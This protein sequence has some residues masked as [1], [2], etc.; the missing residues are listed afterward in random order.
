MTPD[1]FAYTLELTNVAAESARKLIDATL[2]EFNTSQADPGNS[3][4]V[5]IVIKNQS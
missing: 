3:K 4:P 1:S 5:V 2:I